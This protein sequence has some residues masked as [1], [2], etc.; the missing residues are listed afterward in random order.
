MSSF[1]FVS[2]GHACVSIPVCVSRPCLCLHS[3]LAFLS[4]ACGSMPCLLPHSATG[5]E[6]Y[7]DE[8]EEIYD[9]TL[10]ALAGELPS[11]TAK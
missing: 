7:A 3:I 2:P 5:S 10:G 8:P 6:G 11:G 9:D 4:H 1:Q